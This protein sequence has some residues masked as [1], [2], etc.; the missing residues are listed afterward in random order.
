MTYQGVCGEVTFVFAPN[1]DLKA[2]RADRYKDSEANAKLERWEVETK[3]Y[4]VFNGIRVPVESEVTWHL[5]EGDFT[6]FKLMITELDY[7][8]PERFSHD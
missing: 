1:G 5:M 7:H 3:R 8:K 2:C 6:W 4:S